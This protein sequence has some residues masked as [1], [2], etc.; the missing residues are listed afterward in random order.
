MRTTI[1]AKLY[2]GFGSM[3]AVIVASAAFIV[4]STNQA[5]GDYEK[6]SDASR[7]EDLITSAH[8]IT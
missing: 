1:A 3:A 2:F 7:G 6:L 5:Q 8:T 4:Q